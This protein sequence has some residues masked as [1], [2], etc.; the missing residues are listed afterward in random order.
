MKVAIAKEGDF[1][2]EHFGHCT[3]YAVFVVENSKITSK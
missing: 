1:V 2:S 3:E